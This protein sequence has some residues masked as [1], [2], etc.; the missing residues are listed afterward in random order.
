M[1]KKKIIFA[2]ITGVLIVAV[3]CASVISLKE[4]K[5]KKQWGVIQ[6]KNAKGDSW[7]EKTAEKIE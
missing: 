6:L 4:Q 2:V 1:R 5:T 7:A 3:G